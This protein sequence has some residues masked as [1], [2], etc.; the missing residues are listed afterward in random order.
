MKLRI[1]KKTVKI[2]LSKEEILELQSEGFLENHLTISEENYLSYVVEI[3][4]DIETCE[5]NFS[6]NTIEVAIPFDTAEKWIKSNQVAIKQTIET[7]DG[8]TLTLIVEEDL[9]PGKGNS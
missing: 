5:L 1:D 3:L 4:D 2:R 8:E 9:L 7:D 6:S